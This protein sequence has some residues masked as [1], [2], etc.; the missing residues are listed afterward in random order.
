MRCII[1]YNH[2]ERHLQFFIHGAPHRRV[3]R[4]V[5]AKYREEL[6]KAA[7]DAGIKHTIN[8]TVTVS[9]NF[10]D[11]TGPDLDNLIVALWQA[12]D[13]KTG[14]G[15]TI[16]ADDRLIYRIKDMGIMFP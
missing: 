14:K 15:P 13:G 9:A 7:L 5:L 1:R 6:W 12:L 4:A 2:H 3:H 16:L 11:P 8:H 10:I